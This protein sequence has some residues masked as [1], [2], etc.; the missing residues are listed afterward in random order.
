MWP[1]FFGTLKLTATGGSASTAF[2][3]TLFNQLRFCAL[4]DSLSGNLSNFFITSI[5]GIN[6]GTLSAIN[7]GTLS[8]SSREH[9]PASIRD[10]LRYQHGNTFSIITGALSGINTGHFP[11][12]T[13][14]HFHYHHGNSVEW[15][16][17]Q[18]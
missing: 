7:T 16:K 2:V 12:S 1:H 11:A 10:T 9:F 14:E 17:E 3:C 18:K 5:F 8:V 4:A 15:P 13:R 6:T